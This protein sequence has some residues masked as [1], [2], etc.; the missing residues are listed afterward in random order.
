MFVSWGRERGVGRDSERGG[1]G[2][3]ANKKEG[4]RQSERER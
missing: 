3:R 1:G 4:E 2:K